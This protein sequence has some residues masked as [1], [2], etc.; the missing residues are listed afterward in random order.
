MSQLERDDYLKDPEGVH[1][2]D[3]TA[4]HLAEV[5]DKVFA[6]KG[7]REVQSFFDGD[8]KECITVLACGNAAGRMLRPLILY[9]GKLHATSRFD[10]DKR[11]WIGVNGSGY[12]DCAV[13]TA[14]VKNE[15]IPSMTAK[16]VCIS[17]I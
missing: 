5:V 13:F 11:C 15:L 10:E 12:M 6:E 9:D 4:C 16:K 17:G 8:E 3:E 7:T 2:L 1:N 14:Y